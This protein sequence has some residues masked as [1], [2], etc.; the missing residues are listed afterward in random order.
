M[1]D[2]Q[3]RVSSPRQTALE[4]VLE[5]TNSR[6]ILEHTILEHLADLAEQI[7]V[8][9]NHNNHLERLEKLRLE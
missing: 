9:V 4:T 2:L 7:C 3:S 8:V 6:L 1:C 5:H